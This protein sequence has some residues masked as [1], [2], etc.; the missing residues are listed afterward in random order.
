MSLK[1]N[2]AFRNQFSNQFQSMFAIFCAF[3]GSY[4]YFN[5]IFNHVKKILDA[6]SEMPLEN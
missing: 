2:S 4:Y 5:L 1:A 3:S 6:A